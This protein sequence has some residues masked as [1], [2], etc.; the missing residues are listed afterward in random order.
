M[1]PECF[2]LDSHRS[3]RDVN[4]LP[5]GWPASPTS[6]T[7][8]NT[9]SPPASASSSCSRRGVRL[10]PATGDHV[11]CSWSA[12][13]VYHSPTAKPTRCSLRPSGPESTPSRTRAPRRLTN[14]QSRR[15]M[16]V[17]APTCA[18][19]RHELSQAPAFDIA[20]SAAACSL[21]RRVRRRR[22][23]PSSA[24]TSPS[25][26]T[27]RATATTAAA[28]SG[29]GGANSFKLFTWADYDDPDVM[30][31]SATSRSRSSTP[32]RRRSR[33]SSTAGGNG[34]FDMVCP[35]GVYIPQMTGEDL[36]SSST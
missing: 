21:P 36:L 30:A 4:V 23:Q 3:R 13:D 20:G 11:W 26:G 35:T 28:T 31:R 33:S 25:C 9:S 2:R 5:G 17:P 29:N 6:A 16:R 32:W 24:T 27:G 8:C 10:T 14:D 18:P 34:G 19:S 12:D 7:C 1:R 22:R 15:P